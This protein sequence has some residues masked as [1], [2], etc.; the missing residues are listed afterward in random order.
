MSGNDPAATGADGLDLHA[1]LDD[2]KARAGAVWDELT[3]AE[4]DAMKR[5]ADRF[6]QLTRGALTGKADERF[7]AEMAHVQFQAKAFAFRGK[8][9]AGRAFWAAAEAAAKRGAEIALK[10]AAKAGALALASL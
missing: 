8:G 10:L 2:A 1:M 7:D 6:L 5:T 9:L 3:T 4:K